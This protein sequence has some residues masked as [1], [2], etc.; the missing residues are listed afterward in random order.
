[1]GYGIPTI[2]EA[3]RD[4]FARRPVTLPG[5]LFGDHSV[6]QVAGRV[7]VGGQQS[8]S[9]FGKPGGIGALGTIAFVFVVL[10]GLPRLRPW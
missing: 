10:G 9:A 5:Y 6:S 2:K 8:L 1:M 3:A 4:P 7:L